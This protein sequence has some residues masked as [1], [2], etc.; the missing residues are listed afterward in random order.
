MNEIINIPVAHLHPHPDNPRKDLGD[1]TELAD[2]IKQVGI[3]QNLTVVPIDGS[4]EKYG[5]QHYTVI[6]GHRRL[7]AAKLAGL[8]SVPCLPTN[9]SATEQ[10]S[11]MLLE[12]MQRADLTPYEQ[13][14]GFQQLT[15]L[16]CSVEE[17][18]N[19]SG[20]SQSTVRRRL[21]MA[22]LHQEWAPDSFFTDIL[23]IE[24]L[25]E[26]EKKPE[27]KAVY[28]SLLAELVDQ[29]GVGV[30]QVVVSLGRR[31]DD[32]DAVA[33]DLLGPFDGV[34]TCGGA[35]AVDID[36]VTRRQFWIDIDVDGDG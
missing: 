35:A 27:A 36:F 13:A 23:E 25:R 34:G 9:M 15:I 3:L 19:K 12:N 30:D 2:S 18:S 6:I 7:E 10:L 17:I 22:E 8:E 24:A 4:L 31:Q 16:G 1:L 21:K 28:A 11:T 29:I 20:F 14:W 33:I 32:I 5:A 26:A